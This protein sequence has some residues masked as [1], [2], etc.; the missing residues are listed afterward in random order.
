MIYRKRLIK[1]GCLLLLS[2]API[3]ASL[4]G[5][6]DEI[7]SDKGGDNFSRL[8]QLVAESGADARQDF[9]WI[10]LSELAAAY[11]IVFTNSRMEMPKAKKARAK[12]VSWRNGTRRF[13]SE[14]HNLIDRLGGSMEIQMQA[15]EAGPPV[16]YIDGEPVV[17]SGPEIGSARLMEKRIIDTYCTMY[18]CSE[19]SRP[20]EQQTT[21]GITPV[22]GIWTLRNFGKAS[23]Q[24]PDGLIFTFSGMSGRNLKQEI[25]EQI[26]AEMRGLV[27]GLRDAIHAGHS[28]D[29]KHLEIQ[30]L[31]ASRGH[32]IL[33]SRTG[34]YLRM[35]LPALSQLKLSVPGIRTWIEQRAI[36]GM[37][38]EV[39]ILADRLLLKESVNE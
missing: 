13:I 12:L 20:A 38:V 24:T 36:D 5:T 26:A 4:G 18:D 28:I 39:E 31:A 2:A 8:V 9:T 19:L 1:A 32:R 33:F 27:S 14:L 7:V 21:G 17:I 16:I 29:W 3:W 15:E 35:D 37:P 30:P 23:Y 10:A 6:E 22:G 11:E 25:C 34:E